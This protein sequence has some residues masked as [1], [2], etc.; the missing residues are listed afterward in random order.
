M[1]KEREKERKGKSI[2]SRE[3]KQTKVPDTFLL[4]V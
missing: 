2:N 1:K 3:N 4:R